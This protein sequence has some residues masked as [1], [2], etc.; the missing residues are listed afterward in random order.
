MKLKP[1]IIAASVAAAALVAAGGAYAVNAGSGSVA[2]VVIPDVSKDSTP[3]YSQAVASRCTLTNVAKVT[4]GGRTI[5]GTV[6]VAATGGLA[7]PAANMVVTISSVTPGTTFV[8][9]TRSIAAPGPT[10]FNATVGF[11]TNTNLPKETFHV[12]LSY[13]GDG[14]SGTGTIAPCSVAWSPDVAF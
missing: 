2:S 10:N 1:S 5:T 12:V 4:T 13:A 9:R 3:G 11:S 6:Q 8:T 7:T 14:T